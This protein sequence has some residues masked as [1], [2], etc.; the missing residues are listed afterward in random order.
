M[1][2]RKFFVLLVVAAITL[3]LFLAVRH[4]VTLEALIGQ[5]EWLRS[6]TA[7]NPVASLLIAFAAYV[8]ISLI[9]GTTGKSLVFAW[10]FGF[11]PGLLLVNGGLTVAAII[12]FL[13]SRYI[14]QQAVHRRCGN[15][16]RRIDRRLDEADGLF[17][18]TLRLV[19]APYTLTNYA[20]GATDVSLWRFWWTTQLGL[21]PGNVVFA[22]AG[23]NLP[24]LR[25]LARQGF[26][27]LVNFPLLAGLTA[28]AL[29]PVAIRWSMKRLSARR[30]RHRTCNEVSREETTKRT[31]VP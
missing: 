11:L 1:T 16:M 31:G 20:A 2:L 19:H 14:F 18:L 25:E 13:L 15:L 22:Y 7:A 10:L 29:L 26:W 21:L 24:S 4:Y 30:D 27:S 17:L 9:P 3:A 23:A 8:T 12:A 28:V 5:E 6:V